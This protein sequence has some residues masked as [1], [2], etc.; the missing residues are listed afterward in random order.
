LGLGIVGGLVIVEI[1]GARREGNPY[2]IIWQAR[3][4]MH[5]RM[6]DEFGSARGFVWRHAFNTAFE[7]PILGHGPGTFHL[8]LSDEVQNEAVQRFNVFFDSAHNTYLHIAVNLGLPALAAYLV[9]IGSL[10]LPTFKRAFNRPILLAFAAAAA[11]Y[12]VQSFFQIDMLIDRPLLWVAFGIMGGE[13]WRD[14]IGAPTYADK[15]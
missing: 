3:E 15:G 2:D 4:I 9:F 1:E 8:A 10:F 12:L 13:I 14:K 5:G 11:G 6:D 7:N